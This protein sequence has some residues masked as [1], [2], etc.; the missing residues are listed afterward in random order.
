MGMGRC[1]RRLEDGA[2]FMERR[3][4][5]ENGWREL[6]GVWDNRVGSCLPYFRL[7]GNSITVGFG[8]PC[9]FEPNFPG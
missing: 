8:A 1:W 5:G 7:T 6:D 9:F 3:R 2:G 4:I